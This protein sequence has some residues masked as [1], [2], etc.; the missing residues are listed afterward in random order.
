ME[1]VKKRRHRNY[2]SVE[3]TLLL[4]EYKASDV[5]KK[6][7]CEEKDI[8]LS[9]LQR[10]LENEKELDKSTNVQAWAS[11]VTVA[12]EKSAVLPVQI[13]RFTIPVDQYTDMHLLSSVLK[14]VIGIC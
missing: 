10:W 7:W 1:I 2:S 11:I 9:T 14:V 6:D 13:G 3:K 12:P 5:S 8:G 4:E